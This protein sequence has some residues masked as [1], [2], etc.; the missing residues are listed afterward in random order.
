MDA[1]SLYR[2]FMPKYT[3]YS[4][5]GNGRDKY[6]SVNNGG[7]INSGPSS[8]S[9]FKSS[10]PSPNRR[11]FSPAPR[12]ASPVFK[13]HSDGSGRDFYI[14]RDSGGLHAAY[15][16]GVERNIFT[17]TLRKHPRLRNLSSDSFMKMTYNYRS[18]KSRQC[19]REKQKIARNAVNRLYHTNS[20][21]QNIS[22]QDL[23]HKRPC[24][25]SFVQ[26]MK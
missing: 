1:G 23:K 17:S 10:N 18:Q 15:V 6:I 26:T 5:D 22:I 20:G 3:H 2:T 8:P 12:L 16:P 11:F 14:A 9:G 4:N 7:F 24:S 13:Y 19:M 21:S 25:I